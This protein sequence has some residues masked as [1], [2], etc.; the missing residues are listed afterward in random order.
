MAPRKV[1]LV[2]DAVRGLSAREA[3]TRLVFM[4]KAAARPVRKLLQSAMANAEHNFHLSKDSLKI[5]SITVDGGPTLKRSRPR[6]FGRA[7]PI[8]K[9]TAHVNI[10][11]TDE[12]A[13]ESVKS[14]KSVKKEDGRQKTEDKV[15]IEKT[16]KAAAHV[17]ANKLPA[18]S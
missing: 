2:V 18:T 13:K 6:A 9:R 5:K 7:A 11:L 3:E 10:V 15:K 4:N 17:R 16:K 8:R 1:R 12:A 14:I